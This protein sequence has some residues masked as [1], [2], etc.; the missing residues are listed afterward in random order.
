MGTV[1]YPYGPP[2]PPATQDFAATQVLPAPRWGVLHAIGSLL[3]FVVISFGLA[4]ALPV[5]LGVDAVTASIIAT[6]VAWLSLAGWPL[7]VA[8]ARGNGVRAD[9]H[10]TFRWVDLGIGILGAVVVFACAAAFVVIYAGITGTQP[11]STV[12]TVATNASAPWQVYFLA[13]IAVLAPFVEELHFRGMWW[14]ALRRRGLHRWLTLLVTALLFAVVHLEPT[15]VALLFAAGLV[16]GFVRMQTDRLGPAIVV[17][18]IMNA[19]AAL[20]LLSLA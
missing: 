19:I 13:V 3:G 6:P 4:L 18:L 16:L 8:R 1:T 9:L 17:H 10:L 14:S 2:P 7:L 12:G 15:R 20:S 11:T 5:Y